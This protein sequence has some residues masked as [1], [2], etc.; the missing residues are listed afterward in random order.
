[1]SD[2]AET[3]FSGTRVACRV[4][5]RNEDMGNCPGMLAGTLDAV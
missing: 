2:M 4:N 1:M 3:L 5:R